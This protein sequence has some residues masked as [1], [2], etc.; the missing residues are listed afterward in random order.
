LHRRAFASL[1]PWQSATLA[2]PDN[3]LTAPFFLKD[4][5]PPLSVATAARDAGFGAVRAGQPTTTA[6]RF[7]E[8]DRQTGYAQQFNLGLQQEL[9]GRMVLELAYIGNVSRKVAGPN[10]SVA[11]SH[12]CSQPSL[13]RTRLA[14]ILAEPCALSASRTHLAHAGVQ[15]STSLL[16]KL[17]F[18]K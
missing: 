16:S 13:R 3:G 17:A 4:G 8:R 12:S 7:F 5:V 1:T 2:T 15:R 18:P 6:V 11:N 9:P 14:A 10:L